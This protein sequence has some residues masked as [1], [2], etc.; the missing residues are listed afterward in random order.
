[1]NSFVVRPCS[2]CRGEIIL[3][4]DKSIA[5]RAVI[6]SSLSRGP[7]RIENFPDNEDCLATLDVFKRLGV[8]IKWAGTKRKRYVIVSGAGLRGLKRPK[9]PIFIGESGTTFRL[10]L[11]VLAG[12]EFR[13]KLT[14]GKSLSKRP[15]ARVTKPLRMMGAKI[16]SRLRTQNSKQEEYPPITIRGGNLKAITYK[17]PIASAQVKS[18]ILLA[19]LYA[20]G[21]STVIEPISTR[22]HTERMLKLFKSNLQVKGNKITIEGNKELAS[23]KKFYVPGDISSAAFFMVAAA[24]TPN[25]KIVIRNVSLNPTRVGILKVLKRMRADIRLRAPSSE[26][27]AK[28]GEPVGD[29]IIKSSSLKGTKVSRK[30]IPSL[31]DELPILMV[32][33]S[34]A[35]GKS[36]FQGVGEL[37]VKETDRIKS[38][39]ENL[40][41]M[42]AEIRTVKALGN[43]NIVIKG[44]NKFR[45]ARVKSFGDHRTAMSMIVAGLS[46]KSPTLIDDTSCIKKS[47]PDFIRVLKSIEE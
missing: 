44:I 46:A 7:T 28:I 11:G 5:H 45:G 9:G 13:I 19:A 34:L 4:G 12:Q 14:A 21:K 38:M 41:K 40:K 27:R 36:I 39:T 8:R 2:A 47:F 17:M 43:E 29:I 20:K 1:M 26:L 24:V 18:A 6:L 16:D 25:S 15:M 22:D 23:P 42:G 35:R 32:A 30:E 33:A 10:L 3:P 31:I 37:R